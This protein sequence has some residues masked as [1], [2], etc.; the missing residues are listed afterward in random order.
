MPFLGS[1]KARNKKLPS[2]VGKSVAVAVAIR[3]LKL[4]ASWGYK[5][6][7][8]RDC[9]RLYTGVRVVRIRTLF[10]A[11]VWD[12]RPTYTHWFISNKL[13]HTFLSLLIYSYQGES[14]Y[15]HIDMA[16]S[17]SPYIT[18]WHG[19]HINA[20]SLMISVE[21][22]CQDLQTGGQQI[23]VC[24]WLSNQKDTVSCYR[25]TRHKR[26][27]LPETVLTL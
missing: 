26:D 23:R 22:Q 12:P 9:A 18:I 19:I 27:G 2:N 6:K 14:F 4:R 10:Y 11:Y 17:Y 21:W 24:F 8:I 25:R 3:R 16:C 13:T 5:S 15:Q 20:R 1:D 7:L